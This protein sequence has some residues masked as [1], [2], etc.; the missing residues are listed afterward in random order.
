MAIDL[1]KGQDRIYKNL[2]RTELLDD[3]FARAITLFNDNHLHACY[4]VLFDLWYESKSPNRKLFYQ[5]VLQACATLYLIQDGKLCGASKVLCKSLKNLAP[6]AK[7]TKPF[8]IQQLMKDLYSYAST[9]I[10]LKSCDGDM[11]VQL[12]NRPLIMTN[13]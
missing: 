12:M 13:F 6:F 7:I 4:E 11:D 10:M 8:N 3:K 1:G 2:F 5:G 9:V